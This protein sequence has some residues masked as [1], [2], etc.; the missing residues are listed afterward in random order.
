MN[1]KL[2]VCGCN[3]SICEYFIKAECLGCSDIKGEVWWT[4]HISTTVCPIYDCV[5]NEK[6]LKNYEACPEIPCK[7]WWDLKDPSYT[8][9][10][11]E[12]SIRDRV[13][14]LRKLQK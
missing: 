1:A 10:Q 14:N 3:C 6:K 5:I 12:A 7:T 11:H 8:D 9:E 4:S 2:S 13:K